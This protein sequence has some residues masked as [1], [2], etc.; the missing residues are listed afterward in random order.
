[1]KK[2][3]YLILV[4]FV[5]FWA[6]NNNTE[7]NES[8]M[9]PF[10]TEYNTPYDI[11]PFDKIKNEHFM[12]AFDKGIEEQKKE[13][14]GIVNNTEEPAFENTIEALDYSGKLIDKVG[15]VFYNLM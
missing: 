7:N 13:I 14:E 9:N 2:I 12:P 6:C 8:S 15:S 1:M 5:A 3:N 4:L 10:F 11:A